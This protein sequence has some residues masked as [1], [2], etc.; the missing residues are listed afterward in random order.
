MSVAIEKAVATFESTEES[1]IP[2]K[3]GIHFDPG[4]AKQMD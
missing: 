4:L 1:V 2:A 3:A